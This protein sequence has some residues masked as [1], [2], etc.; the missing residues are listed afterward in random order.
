MKKRDTEEL[1]IEIDAETGDEIVAEES[2]L[3]VASLKAKLKQLRSELVEVKKERDENLTGWQR[4]KAD[5][6]NFRRNTEEDRQRDSA[7]Q[8]GKII[9]SVLPALDSFESA[10]GD[11]SWQD[12]DPKWREGVERIR[13]QLTSALEREGL[14]TYG[15][16]GEVFDPSYHDCMSVASTDDEKQDNTIAQILQ[17]G[18]KIG[19]EVVRPAKVIVFQ[20]A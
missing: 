13:N 1:E 7:R 16:V 5:L 12:I 17:K 10:V 9:Q 3:S 18:Y 14:T 15:E 20:V 6:I 2:E 8:K 19:G 4:V 11:K